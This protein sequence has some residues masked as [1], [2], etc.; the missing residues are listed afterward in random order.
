VLRILAVVVPFTEVLPAM[1]VEPRNC[2]FFPTD[3]PPAITTAPIP[4]L[5]E[6]VVLE[7]EQSPEIVDVDVEFVKDKLPDET[8][9]PSILNVFAM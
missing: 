1:E 6:S 3:K 9:F 8:I 7:N 2:V 4:P 5:V